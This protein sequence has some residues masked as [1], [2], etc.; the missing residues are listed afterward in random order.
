[1][2]NSY[3]PLTTITSNDD[4][5]YDSGDADSGKSRDWDSEPGDG[6]YSN[7]DRGD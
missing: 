2:C 4:D 6:R 1:M 7:S 3:G 5:D